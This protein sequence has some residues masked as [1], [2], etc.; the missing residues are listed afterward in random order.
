MIWQLLF[1]FI[2]NRIFLYL[3]IRLSIFHNKQKFLLRTV[4]KTFFLFIIATTVYVAS[5]SF[6]LSGNTVLSD[7]IS[8]TINETV[9]YEECVLQNFFNP[10]RNDTNKTLFPV[11]FFFNIKCGEIESGIYSVLIQPPEAF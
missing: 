8:E 10:F 11:D 3:C 7:F 1:R 6:V 2:L 4:K 5:A 9:T